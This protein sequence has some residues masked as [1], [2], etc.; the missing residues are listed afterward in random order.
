MRRLLA[1]FFL[2]MLCLSCDGHSPGHGRPAKS[3]VGEALFFER[4]SG[5]LRDYRTSARIY[6]D[7]CREGEGDL[8]ACRL[9]LHA[10]VWSKGM[11]YGE[12]IAKRVGWRACA[13]GSSYACMAFGIVNGSAKPTPEQLAI[14]TA[15]IDNL[16]SKC[17]S[18]NL[19][20]CE[21]MLL[22]EAI[23]SLATSANHTEERIATYGCAEILCAAGNGRGC[24]F[25]SAHD[26]GSCVDVEPPAKCIRALIS[27]WT[28][29]GFSDEL[30]NLRLAQ[31]LCDANDADACAGIPGR[32]I[33]DS[34]LC[35]A[36][37][38]GACAKAACDGNVG[39]R[40][41]ATEHGVRLSC[42][43]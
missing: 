11:D 10:L 13:R 30:R 24:Q 1:G 37:D 41:I 43:P 31:R 20:A 2:M 15:A 25:T 5:N 29:R 17:S 26:L 14:V 38:Y 40:R 7:L 35:A 4:A 27:E 3:T 21:A 32:H 42:A 33:P 16:P 36:G 18:T 28:E 34:T 39:A 22:Q 9:F 6:G 8:G 23:G 19:V 12:A